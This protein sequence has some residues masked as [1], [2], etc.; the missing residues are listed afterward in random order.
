VILLVAELQDLK[1]DINVRAEGLIIESYMD[2][3]KGPVATAIIQKGILRNKDIIATDLALAKVKHIEDFKWMPIKEAHPSQPVIILGF[4]TVPAV[5]EKFKR[6]ETLQ[7]VT[8][9][10]DKSFA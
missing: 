4:N 10:L 9:K 3:L 7:S 6:Y 5:G 8:N 1:T 2:E